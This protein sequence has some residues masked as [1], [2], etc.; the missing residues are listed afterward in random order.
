MVVFAIGIENTLLV[1]MYRLERR[2]ARENI[3]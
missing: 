1:P 3:G 2:R